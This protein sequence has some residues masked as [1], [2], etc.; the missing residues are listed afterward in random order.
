MWDIEFP[1]NQQRDGS[2]QT[3][4][5]P[6][7]NPKALQR[8][9]QRV[10]S[11][12]TRVPTQTFSSFSRSLAHVR[13]HA[14]TRASARIRLLNRNTQHAVSWTW[15]LGFGW[16][17]AQFSTP[18]FRAVIRALFD[19][20]AAERLT[21]VLWSAQRDHWWIQSTLQHLLDNRWRVSM[22]LE[23]SMICKY[24]PH[25]GPQSCSLWYDGQLHS[26]IFLFIYLFILNFKMMSCCTPFF[27]CLASQI[28]H[29][30]VFFVRS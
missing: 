5:C 24:I 10:W 11:G 19:F 30:V 22:T 28:F 7:P 8:W 6:C 15:S 21:H 9:L 3:A 23:S 27:T 4:V 13:V 1:A 17:E 14:R 25:Q 20:Q 12:L 18:V 29:T 16:R 26:G 2:Q